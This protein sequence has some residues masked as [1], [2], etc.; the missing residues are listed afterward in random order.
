MLLPRK[1]WLALCCLA[2]C[3]LVGPALAFQADA[4]PAAIGAGDAAYLVDNAEV[5]IKLNVKQLLASKL[6]QE[7]TDALKAA[8]NSNRELKGVLDATGIDVTKDI[9]SVLISAAGTNPTDVKAQIAVRGTFDT[10]KI[11]KVLAKQDKVKVVKEGGKELYEL[12][13]PQGGPLYAAFVDNKTLVLTPS[14]ETTA[15]FAKGTAKKG[16]I[17]KPMREAL[18][19]FTGK[20]SVAVA[21]GVTDEIRNLLKGSPQGAELAKLQTLNASVT[22]TDGVTL[23]LTG[24]TNDAEAAKS[25]AAVLDKLKG[26]GKEFVPPQATDLYDAIKVGS[27]KGNVTIDL[28]VS[29][30]TIEK[31]KK[32]G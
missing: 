14:K 4:P 31:L 7:H 1:N 6:A 19:R 13:A 16:T 30:E 27:T 17:S 23:N 24:I 12:E 8:I 25:M 18:G 20:E 28:K 22:V 10:A 11:G 9:D 5:I 21:A 15:S 29:K 3:L 2:L 26:A 32:G